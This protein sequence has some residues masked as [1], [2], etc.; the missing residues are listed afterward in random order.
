MISILII[1]AALI[2]ILVFYFR[3]KKARALLQGQP[4]TQKHAASP[5][6]TK[7]A[8]PVFQSKLMET[9]FPDR[10]QSMIWH[11]QAIQRGLKDGDL[12]F[13]NLSFAKLVES[14]R[15]QMIN[16][17]EGL[18]D[19][20]DAV[21]REYDSFRE[22]YGLAY[23]AQ[24][25]PPAQKP[26][27]K[28]PVTSP[29]QPAKIGKGTNVKLHALIAGLEGKGHPQFPLLRKEYDPGSG[30][31]C[32]DFSGWIIGRLKERDK[33]SLWAFVKAL[34]L[35]KEDAFESHL[36]Q[37][38]SNFLSKSFTSLFAQIEEQAVF[39]IQAFFILRHGIDDF[40]RE[41]WLAEGKEAELL[42]KVL[43]VYNFSIAPYA[44]EPLAKKAN[45]FLREMRKDNEYWKGYPN[46]N[47]GKLPSANEMSTATG[48]VSKLK[49]LTPAERLHFFDFARDAAPGSF[50]SGAS[51]Y[52]TRTIGI[53]EEKSTAKMVSLGI[54]KLMSNVNAIPETISKPELKELAQQAG[55]EV[56]KS[57]TLQATFDNLMK[58]EQGQYF[59]KELAES[60]P[61]LTFNGEYNQ[62]LK[63]VLDHQ[64]RIKRTVDLLAMA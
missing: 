29:V 52:K 13:V 54:F 49:L 2:G 46:Y 15:Q 34:Y 18:R 32:C 25:L 63:Q 38:F 59:L 20:F 31:P 30:I 51:S 61:T 23:P 26:I 17:G 47:I 53:D 35:D 22:T 42:C 7:T 28:Q 4:A 50:W 57:W 37:S 36:R 41:F 60:K 11:S 45:S 48:L 12:N 16:E 24:F 1:I 19:Y 9:P 10:T 56:K 8:N 21:A 40:N 14:I 43:C 64:E 58:T 27:S 33:E 5:A 62:D 6:Q 55:F 3:K 44:F 39:E